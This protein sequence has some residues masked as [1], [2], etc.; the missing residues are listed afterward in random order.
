[1]LVLAIPPFRDGSVSPG[2]CPVLGGWYAGS[3]TGGS[4]AAFG[5]GR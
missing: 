1:M 2:C 3:A 5:K 4:A